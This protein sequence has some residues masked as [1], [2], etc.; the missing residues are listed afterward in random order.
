MNWDKGVDYVAVYNILRRNLY[1]RKKREICYSAILLIQLR[2]GSRISE[3]VEGFKQYLL[4]RKNEIYV[5][6]RKKKREDY[7]L[8]II[9]EELLS[10]DLSIC[11]DLL[12]IDDRK[13]RD[14]VR[15]YISNKYKINTHSLRYAFIT[16]LL[17]NNINVSII[18]KITHHSNLNYILHYTQQ[19]WSEEVLKNIG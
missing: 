17:K 19:K 12:N 18:A 13:L 14:R 8:M 15:K 9:P 6:V 2:N 5:R 10:V 16:Y 3:A 11:G 7:R 4:T 1:S